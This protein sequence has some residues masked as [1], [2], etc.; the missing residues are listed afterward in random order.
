[1]TDAILL[2][3]LSIL[4]IMIWLLWMGKR[5]GEKV[6]DDTPT[7]ALALINELEWFECTVRMDNR[8]GMQVIETAILEPLNAKMY[9][10]KHKQAIA[11]VLLYSRKMIEAYPGGERRYTIA[12]FY[13]QMNRGP[14][15]E[16]VVRIEYY[17]QRFIEKTTVTYPL[18]SGG[19][20]KLIPMQGYRTV[21]RL[22][23]LG[24]S[25]T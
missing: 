10:D 25:H 11:M 22:V 18:V 13:E 21:L 5:R 2:I 8:T 4:V 9:L 3:V 7:E 24:A 12:G 1:M 15:L 14:R 23:V 20:G 17:G 6:E 16:D 19:S